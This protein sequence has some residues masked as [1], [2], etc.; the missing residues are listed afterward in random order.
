MRQVAPLPTAWA[1][2]QSLT[3]IVAFCSTECGR[4]LLLPIVS[5]RLFVVDVMGGSLLVTDNCTKRRVCILHCESKQQPIMSPAMSSRHSSIN[6]SPWPL[7]EMDV[8]NQ[9]IMSTSLISHYLRVGSHQEN[10]TPSAKPATHHRQQRYAG[11]GGVDYVAC[12]RS[13]LRFIA[14][15]CQTFLH[16][17]RVCGGETRGGASGAADIVMSS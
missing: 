3:N 7:R 2:Y 14:A 17:N 9:A 11:R 8:T 5:G 15:G 6:Q 4:V 12:M 16:S 13:S 1:G 10:T